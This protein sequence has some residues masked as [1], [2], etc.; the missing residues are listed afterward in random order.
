MH[1]RPATPRGSSPDN[2]QVHNDVAL[3]SAAPCTHQ[4]VFTSTFLGRDRRCAQ[5]RT[6]CEVNRTQ[7]GSASCQADWGYYVLAIERLE[8]QFER[9]NFLCGCRLAPGPRWSNFNNSCVAARHGQKSPRS[10]RG[11]G[12]EISGVSF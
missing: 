1:L 8:F 4:V 12:V 9:L 11:V 3:G 2:R 5:R 6:F 10:E 7:Q